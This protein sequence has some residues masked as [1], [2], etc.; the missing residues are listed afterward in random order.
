MQ[1]TKPSGMHTMRSLYKGMSKRCSPLSIYGKN[2]SNKRTTNNILTLLHNYY[3]KEQLIMKTK[4][5]FISI[6]T[7]CIALSLTAC[8]QRKQTSTTDST[9]TQTATDTEK[10]RL[11]VLMIYI[12]RKIS[13]LQTTLMHGTRFLA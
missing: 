3:L 10:S 13:F 11:N 7:L 12:S 4:L 8:R 5:S 2:M 1:N 9:D 6:L